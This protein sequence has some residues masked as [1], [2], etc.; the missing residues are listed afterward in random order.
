MSQFIPDRSGN[1]PFNGIILGDANTKPNGGVYLLLGSRNARGDVVV[2]NSIANGSAGNTVANVAG[3]TYALFVSGSFGA[4]GS[5]TLQSVDPDGTARNIGS[6]I[7]SSGTTGSIAIGEGTTVRALS[8][9]SNAV[10][11]AI[12]EL[13]RVNT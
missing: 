5:I 1:N 2:A 7:T 10:T 13:R 4:A 12:V 6:A 11:S 8:S 3:G 9:G